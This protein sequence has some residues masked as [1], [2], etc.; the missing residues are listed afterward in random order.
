MNT[1]YKIEL[2]KVLHRKKF[3]VFMI[4]G[5]VISVLW[6]ILSVYLQKSLTGDLASIFGMLTGVV[7]LGPL[8]FLVRFMLPL[9]AF[10]AVTDLFTSELSDLTI[11][12][13]LIRPV[14]RVKLYGAKILAIVTYLAIYLG[15]ILVLST[16]GG[17]IT[18]DFA[19]VKEVL[20]SV[21]AYVV[22]IVPLTVMV[23]FAAFVALLIKSSSLAMFVL[24]FSYVLLSALPLILPIFQRI[25]FTSYLEWYRQLVGVI[26]GMTLF[27]TIIILFSYG[28]VFFIAG[29]M[30]FDKKDI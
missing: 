3:V 13:S 11:K 24:I 6:I 7:P 5:G 8:P 27:N 29:S 26:P 16:V 23:C 2:D 22:S 10:M 14:F 1:V 4:I 28:V 15:V 25:L 20:L 30:V 17:I 19:S 9:L 21:V 18:A 12:A